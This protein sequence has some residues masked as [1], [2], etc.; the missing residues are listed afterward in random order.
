V[1]SALA[2]Y[3]VFFVYVWSGSGC[4]EIN[5]VCV[6]MFIQYILNK[7]SCK[8]PVVRHHFLYEFQFEIQ[9]IQSI[10]FCLRERVVELRERKSNIL[11]VCERV[12]KCFEIWYSS[13]NSEHKFPVK[14]NVN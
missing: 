14:V 3:V 1:C 13:S 12:T 4:L 10:F 8:S 11:C 9:G 6:F 7:N 5:K 2:Y